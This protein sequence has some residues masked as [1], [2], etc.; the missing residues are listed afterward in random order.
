MVKD[1]V[2]TRIFRRIGHLGLYQV[3]EDNTQSRCY[4]CH[5]LDCG[6]KDDFKEIEK[7]AK[8]IGAIKHIYIDAKE[9]FALTYVIPC[10]KANGLYQGKYPLATA[11]LAL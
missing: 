6:Q 10:I 1:K 2:C 11:L 3:F 9:E 4:H 5:S 7:N 8:S